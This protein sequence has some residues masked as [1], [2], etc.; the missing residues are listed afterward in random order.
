MTR[1]QLRAEHSIALAGPVR[2]ALSAKGGLIAGNLPPYE[3]F[4]I[5][6][7]NSVRGWEEGGVGTGRRFAVGSAELHV[8]LVAPVAGV[9]FADAGSDLDTGDTVLG[10]PARTRGKPGT[11]CGVGAGVRLDSPVGPLRLEY[12]FNDRGARRFHFGIGKAF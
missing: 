4:P 8:P 7:T 11:G 6:G 5:G 9:L 2:L 10:E 3:A 1:L 12:A